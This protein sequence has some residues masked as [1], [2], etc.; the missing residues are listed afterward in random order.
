MLIKKNP[1][2]TFTIEGYTDSFGDA[3]YN[4]QL[5]QARADAVRSWLIQ[6]MDVNPSNIKAIGYGATRFLVTPKPV[7]MRSQPSIEQEKLLEQSNRRVEI[8]FKF[9]VK[10]K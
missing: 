8:K 10:S 4:L 9:P 5:S 2:V 7:D 6:N 3:A 1:K